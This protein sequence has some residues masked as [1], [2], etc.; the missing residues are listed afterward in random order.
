MK[1]GVIAFTLVLALIVGF[2]GGYFVNNITTTKETVA[3]QT[4]IEVVGI[5]HSSNW[6]NR[7]ATLVLNEDFTCKYP[8]GSQGTWNQEKNTIK[9]ALPVM[10]LEITDTKVE[11]GIKAE[12]Y[13]YHTAHVVEDGIIL[14]DHYFEKK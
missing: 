1:K 10:N 8:G 5:Y 13:D 2:I 6:N 11:E 9:I 4:A 12:R 14:H 7:E 3:E